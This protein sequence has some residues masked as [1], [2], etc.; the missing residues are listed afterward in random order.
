MPPEC[1]ATGRCDSLAPMRFAC[2]TL[3]LPHL[4][5]SHPHAP[6]R[7]ETLVGRD[8]GNARQLFAESGGGGR[9]RWARRAP[10]SS[11]GGDQ[12]TAVVLYHLGV[13]EEQLR[14]R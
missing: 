11:G 1:H 10:S 12:E 4:T 14:H 3:A 8:R 5:P 9:G 6:S 13:C 2:M 7:M